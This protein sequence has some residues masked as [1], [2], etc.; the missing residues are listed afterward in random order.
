MVPTDLLKQYELSI[1][2]RLI[3][4]HLSTTSTKS[5]D[6]IILPGSYS[7]RA[8]AFGTRSPIGPFSQLAVLGTGHMTRSLHGGSAL[9]AT[10]IT[11]WKNKNQI[12]NYWI[13]WT[14]H[15]DIFTP[16]STFS[17]PDVPRVP[18]GFTCLE[19]FFKGKH[20]REN[21]WRGNGNFPSDIHSLFLVTGKKNRYRLWE[22]PAEQSSNYR[23]PYLLTQKAWEIEIG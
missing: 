13:V 2:I 11:I 12:Q 16:V 22:P 15:E 4:L 19:N 17:K 1:D 21:I 3:S 20:I 14:G 23:L 9:K 8:T 6:E 18:L 10:Q 5:E 7:G